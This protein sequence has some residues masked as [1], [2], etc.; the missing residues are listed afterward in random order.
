MGLCGSF[1]LRGS[2]CVCYTAVTLTLF[3][4]AVQAYGCCVSLH[5][6]M[7]TLIPNK[8]HILGLASSVTLPGPL[9]LLVEVTNLADQR[10]WC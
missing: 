2:A 3:V 8:A 1:A 5:Q 9:T 4:R 7:I 10:T 6:S